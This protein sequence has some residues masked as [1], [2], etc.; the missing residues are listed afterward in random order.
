MS[1]D[2]KAPEPDIYPDL[3]NSTNP[4]SSDTITTLSDYSFVSV[5]DNSKLFRTYRLVQLATRV[6]LEYHG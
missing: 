2:R 4:D 6:W 3:S 5:S 1:S